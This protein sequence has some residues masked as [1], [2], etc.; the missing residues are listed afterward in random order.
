MVWIV[1]FLCVSF[2]TLV[3]SITRTFGAACATAASA[4]IVLWINS[5]IFIS[6]KTICSFKN[7]EGKIKGIFNLNMT[8]QGSKEEKE[9]EKIASKIWNT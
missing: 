4:V 5:F 9:R 3:R 6:L 1:F 2:C 7:R 8:S